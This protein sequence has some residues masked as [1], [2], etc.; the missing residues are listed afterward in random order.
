M[1]TGL[2]GT[3]FL[4]IDFKMK[5][6]KNWPPRIKFYPSIKQLQDS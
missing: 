2:G 1:T 4:R 5:I 3:S 6:L